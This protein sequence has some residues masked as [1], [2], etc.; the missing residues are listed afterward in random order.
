MLIFTKLTDTGP[1]SSTIGIIDNLCFSMS[2]VY[3]FLLIDAQVIDIDWWPKFYPYHKL[4][5]CVFCHAKGA[6]LW[7]TSENGSSVVDLILVWFVLP[8]VMIF[9]QNFLYSYF[10]LT[11]IRSWCDTSL[12]LTWTSMNGP[13]F[14][15]EAV[16]SSKTPLLVKL[17]RAAHRTLLR[18]SIMAQ[19]ELFL[20]CLRKNSAKM[21][22][23]GMAI[24]DWEK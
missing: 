13:L 4:I 11:Q 3:C 8:R 5:V 18:W 6:M 24:I 23:V 22:I 10:Y 19:L 14:R 20:K 9:K 12:P 17:R 15:T 21:F 2:Y 16:S 7:N 1:H